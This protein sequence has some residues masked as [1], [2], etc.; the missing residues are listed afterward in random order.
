M[1]GG[2][3]SAERA[4]ESD[5]LYRHSHATVA[6]SIIAAIDS[7]SGISLWFSYALLPFTAKGGTDGERGH[8][9]CISLCA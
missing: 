2:I 6:F 1:R 7:R 8:V 9:S 3:L 4:L 5:L